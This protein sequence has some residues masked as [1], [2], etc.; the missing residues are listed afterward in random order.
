M[1]YSCLVFVVLTLAV[2]PFLLL[3]LLFALLLMFLVAKFA[4]RTTID[5]L[6]LDAISR[7]PINSFFSATL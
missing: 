6:R 7:S 1:F 3:L 2:Y 4:I 5:A